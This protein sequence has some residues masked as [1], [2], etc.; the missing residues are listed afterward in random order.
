MAKGTISVQTHIVDWEVDTYEQNGRK[1]SDWD[2][3]E[4]KPLDDVRREF[5]KFEESNLERDLT[6][7]ETRILLKFVAYCQNRNV[8]RSKVK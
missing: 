4:Q 8:N 1:E 3:I 6:F 5:V 7:S 2:M